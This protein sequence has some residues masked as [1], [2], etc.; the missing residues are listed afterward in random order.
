MSDEIYTDILKKL[1]V[2]PKNF[3]PICLDTSIAGR[4]RNK[5]NEHFHHFQNETFGLV[6]KGIK[7]DSSAKSIW[8]KTCAIMDRIDDI[9]MYLNDIKLYE[10]PKRGNE[11]FNYYNLLN[12]SYVLINCID[13]LLKYF[14][15]NSLTKADLEN[16][17]LDYIVE[18]CF[19]EK[20]CLK[21]SDKKFFEYIRSLCSVHPIE[22]SRHSQLQNHSTKVECSPFMTDCD[23]KN[24][25]FFTKII[26]Y[27]DDNSFSKHILIDWKQMIDYITYRYE[28]LN[29]VINGIDS[30]FNN[31]ECGYRGT[32]LKTIIDF[33]N[34]YSKYILYLKDEMVK[35]VEDGYEEC[36]VL[37][38]KILEYIPKDRKNLKTIEQYKKVIISSLKE[39]AD[40][41]QNLPDNKFFTDTEFYRIQSM[42]TFGFIDPNNAN[43]Y[44]KRYCFEKLS[45]LWN[46]YRNRPR[47]RILYKYYGE[48]LNNY[49]VLN[50]NMADEEISYLVYAATYFWAIKNNKY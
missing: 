25:K 41:L 7:E 45:S 36:F 50:D 14:D 10:Y 43:G 30:Y 38:A 8:L 18:D 31:V 1:N 22:T 9:V 42:P 2:V 5:V 12:H 16:S 21:E 28:L 26:V 32:K 29:N 47:Y 6:N 4:L 39:L 24:R 34:N 44:S 40:Y 49:V 11:I 37:F 19:C 20:N 35:R 33:N 15:S 3:M 23:G 13:I 46:I 48:V 27:V 17:R